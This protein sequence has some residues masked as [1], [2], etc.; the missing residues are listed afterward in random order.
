MAR[1][2]LFRICGREWVSMAISSG[3][4]SRPRSGV[5]ICDTPLR[6]IAMS[7]GVEVRSCAGISVF[8]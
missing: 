7:A 8:P 1:I 5:R 3:L 6:V 2:A 4:R